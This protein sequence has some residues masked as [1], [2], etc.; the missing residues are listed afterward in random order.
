[1]SYELKIDPKHRAA[2][3]FIGKVRKALVLAALDEKRAS[4]ITQKKVADALGRDRSVVNRLLRGEANLTLRTVAEIA[5]AL[6]WEP[7]FSLKKIAQPEA[8]ANQREEDTG[9]RALRTE[10]RSQQ[11]SVVYRHEGPSTQSSS[12]RSLEPAA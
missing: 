2:G 11:D 1:M 9:M 10:T 8:G 12:N 4:G 6:G 5:W 3:R 7:E